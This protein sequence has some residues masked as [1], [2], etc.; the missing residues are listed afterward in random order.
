[1]RK[2]HE[3]LYTMKLL[4][5]YIA[6]IYINYTSPN[7][8]THLKDRLYQSGNRRTIPYSTAH[9]TAPVVRYGVYHGKRYVGKIHLLSISVCNPTPFPSHRLLSPS[10]HFLLSDRPLACSHLA[11]C[12]AYS[13]RRTNP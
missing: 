12:E 5:L 3:G 2:N 10:L 8:S 11:W 7:A 4:Y 9:V 1:M 13:G 6:S